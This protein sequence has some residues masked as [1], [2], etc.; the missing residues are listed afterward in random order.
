MKVSLNLR[1]KYAARVLVHQKPTLMSRNFN[2]RP[3]FHLNLV[4]SQVLLRNVTLGRRIMMQLKQN[5]IKLLCK[6]K[7]RSFYYFLVI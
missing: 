7:L 5:L 4:E 1:M 3:T 6:V 2:L